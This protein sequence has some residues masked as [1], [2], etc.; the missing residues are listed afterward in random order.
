MTTSSLSTKQFPVWVVNIRIQMLGFSYIAYPF[1][2]TIM[3]ICLLHNFEN[4]LILLLF[5]R[6][7]LEGWARVCCVDVFLVYFG[8]LHW[9]L[10]ILRNGRKIKAAFEVMFFIYRTKIKFITCN[11][12]LSVV[13]LL[14]GYS[15]A[16]N[17]FRQG[18]C[19]KCRTERVDDMVYNFSI[20]LKNVLTMVNGYTRQFWKELKETT[21][22]EKVYTKKKHYAFR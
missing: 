14:P 17:G 9:V 18:L 22:W 1:P 20:A 5:W 6:D 21:R 10:C 8:Y 7:V 15:E 19:T 13:H 2:V 12:N 4:L 3:R 16:L 11:K